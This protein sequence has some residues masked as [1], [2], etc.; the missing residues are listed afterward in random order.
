MNFIRPEL[1][2]RLNRW[3]ETI[4]GLGA[5]ALGLVWILTAD[6]ALLLIGSV[7]TVGGALLIFAGIQRAR[8]RQGHGGP[9]YVEV[10]EAQL[11]YFGPTEGGTVAV[12]DLVRLEFDPGAHPSAE[13][14]IT[15]TSGEAISIPVNAEGADALFDVFASLPGIETERMLSELSRRP[16]DR[17]V[18]WQRDQLAVH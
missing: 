7:L 6:G 2:R 13:W 17:V 5:A 15:A 14:V 11:T 9:G 12:G 1:A 10:D 18:I 16:D 3:R 4:A 8:F